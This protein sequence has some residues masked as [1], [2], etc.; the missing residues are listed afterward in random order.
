MSALGGLRVLDLSRVLAGPSCGQLF[1][2]LGAHV[3]KIEEREGDENRR[4]LPVV[5]GRGANFTSV[6]RGKRGMTLNLKSAGGR[7]V[8]DRLVRRADVL[9]ENF[10]PDTAARL[11]LSWERLSAINENLVHVS[12]TGYG[13]SGPL[14]SRPGY[15]NMLQAFTGM[16]AMTGEADAGPARLGPS[17][18]DMGTGM[19]AFAGAC[20]ALLARAQGRARGQHVET[21][22]MQTAISQLGYHLT[23][24][25]MAGVVP[26]RTGSAVWHIVPYQAFR[27]ADGW[28]LAGATN[29]AVWVRLAQVLG[30]PELASDAR[31]ADA[32]GRSERRE[33]LIALISPRFLAHDTATWVER[34]DAAR[35]PCSPVQDVAQLLAHPQVAAMDMLHEVDDGRG[36]RLRLAGVPL[37]MSATP[38]VPGRRPPDLGEHT[39]EILRDDLGMTDE[40][41]ARL[42]TEGA[43]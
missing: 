2:D 20:A 16:M 1:A 5:D 22:L 6:N 43:V 29:D 36:G 37:R 15:D 21:S 38:P 19:L 30:V 18:I 40:E 3:I 31:F 27:T 7:D 42:K 11:G 4:W 8:L 41:I 39:E 32:Q 13:A 28:V 25:T 23:G 9:I 12:I 17:V 14:A 33:E 35:V 26:Q 34:L 10:P 24:Y